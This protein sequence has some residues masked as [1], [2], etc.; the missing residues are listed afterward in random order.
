[1]VQYIGF[2][3]KTKL[4]LAD[5]AW[6]STRSPW[7]DLIIFQ[8]YHS[9][10]TH[11]LENISHTST[12]DPFLSWFPSAF[13][14]TRERQSTSCH[15]IHCSLKSLDNPH[16]HSI[17]PS[18]GTLH[19]LTFHID[20]EVVRVYVARFRNNEDSIRFEEVVEIE[21]LEIEWSTYVSWGSTQNQHSMMT[22]VSYKYWAYVDKYMFTH[23]RLTGWPPK[24]LTDFTIPLSK[25]RS[26]SKRRRSLYSV[27]CRLLG[28][29][30]ASV[31][32]LG[33]ARMTTITQLNPAS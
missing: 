3:V 10:I 23:S 33:P 1:M 19:D 8:N 27:S 5:L 29:S 9:F 13:L 16:E 32:G 15:V 20:H 30:L 14:T 12:R 7:H 28:W 24:V 31:R 4:I 6:F 2:Y 22:R 18:T 21:H 25:L 11:A 26:F 17:H